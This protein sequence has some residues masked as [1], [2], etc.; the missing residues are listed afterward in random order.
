MLTCAGE[1]F[2]SRMAASLLTALGVPELITTNLEEYVEKAI[3]LANAPKTLARIRSR[4][5]KSRTTKGLYDA[6]VFTKNLEAAFVKMY[7]VKRSGSRPEHI[8]VIGHSPE[9][10][11]A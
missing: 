3:T 9:E 6:K 10:R 8:S 1:A 7:D 4:M 11:A 5:N 2:A